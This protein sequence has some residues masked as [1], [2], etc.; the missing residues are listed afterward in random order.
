MHMLYMAAFVGV[1]SG[2]YIF[3]PLLQEYQEDSHG[4]SEVNAPP[5]SEA[6]G[7]MASSR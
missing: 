4:D 7:V 2:F 5:S 3:K 1:G 6:P